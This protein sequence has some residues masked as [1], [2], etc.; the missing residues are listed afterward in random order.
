M[1]RKISRRSLLRATGLSLGAVPL[2]GACASVQD[3]ASSPGPESPAPATE[4][5]ASPQA[6]G[7]EFDGEEITLLVYSGLTETLYRDFF[8]PQFEAAT[9]ASVTIDSAW[10]EGIARLDAAP[11]EAPPFDLVLTDPTQGLPAVEQGLFQQFDVDRVP[12]AAA[13]FH[14]NLLNATVYDEGFGIP[15]H[16]S[17]MTLATNT[18]LEAEPFT[19]WGELL[20]RTPERGFMLYNLSYMSLYT[21]AEMMAEAEGLEPGMGVALLED[22]L[23]GVLAFAAA[24]GDQ[25]QFYWPSTADGVNALVNG[26][27]AA[28][29]IHGNGLLAPIKDGEPVQGTIPSGTDAYVQLF[30]SVPQNVRNVDLSLAALDHICSREFQQSLAESGEYSCAIPDIAETYAASD[31]VWAAAFPASEEDF[32]NLKYYPY[33]VYAAN[34]DRIAEVWDNDVLRA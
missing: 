26:E 27:V 22:D 3:T 8:V 1:Q 30:F 17:A 20:E 5:S 33:D 32:A 6:A 31:E 4:G 15:F 24:N 34:A 7:N 10:T 29:N 28:G 13:N 16:S 14:P 19:T 21:F 11:T 2:L 25:V 23:E 9:G 12:N 18:E